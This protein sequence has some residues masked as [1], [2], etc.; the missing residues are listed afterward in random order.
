MCVLEGKEMKVT[1]VCGEKDYA[2]HRQAFEVEHSIERK[3]VHI[4]T[5]SLWSAITGPRGILA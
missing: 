4:A 2:N 5:L 3:Y 1:R